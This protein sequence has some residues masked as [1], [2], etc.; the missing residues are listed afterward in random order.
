MNSSHCRKILPFIFAVL[1]LLLA[2]LNSFVFAQEQDR[3]KSELF[4]EIETA[5]K[6][7]QQEEVPAFAPSL[8]E[9]AIKLYKSAEKDYRD[10]ERLEDIRETLRDAVKATNEAIEAANISKITLAKASVMRKEAAQREYIKLAPSEFADAEKSYEDAIQKVEAGDIRAARKKTEEAMKSYREEII[11]AM[12][13]G[14]LKEAS[15]RLD[16]SKDV[17]SRE[18]VNKSKRDLGALEDQLDDARDQEFEIPVL[19][20][21]VHK[22]IDAIIC[23]IDPAYCNPPDTLVMGS[24]ILKVE[25]YDPGRSWD[26]ERNVMTNASGVAWTSFSCDFVTLFPIFSG[27]IKLISKTFQVV[28]I[29]S[30]TLTEINLETAKLINPEVKIGETLQLDIPSKSDLHADILKGKRDLIDLLGKPKGTI[31]VRFENLTIEP[32]AHS[33]VG[34]VLEGTAHYPTVPPTPDRITLSIAGFKVYI[35]SLLL[36]PAAATAQ[37][38]LEFPPSIVDLSECRPGRVSLGTISINSSCQ[39]HKELYDNTFGPWVMDNTG[40]VFGGTGFVA[41]FSTSWMVP[42]G[43]DLPPMLPAWRGVVLKSGGTVAHSSIDTSNVGFLY[44]S[45]R[46]TNATVSSSGLNTKLVLDSVSKYMTLAPLAYYIILHGGSLQIENGM[47]KEGSF[48]V[49]GELPSSVKSDGGSPIP[50]HFDSFKVDSLLNITGV[51][52]TIHTKIILSE[53]YALAVRKGNF[54]LPAAPVPLAPLYFDRST[55]NR[56]TIESI[57]DTM[58]LPGLTIYRRNIDSLM[59]SSKDVHPRFWVKRPHGWLN[60]VT[61]GGVGDIYLFGNPKETMDIQCRLGQPGTPGYKSDSTFATEFKD[62]VIV[63][64]VHNAVY[65]TYFKGDITIPYP[66]GAAVVGVKIPFYDMGFT[67]IGACVGGNPVFAD[68]ITLDYWGVGITSKWGVVSVRTGEILYTDAMITE[69]RHFALG[70]NIYWGEMRADGNLGNFF[71]NYNS[72][73]QKF[74]GFPFTIHNA[75]LSRY[76]PVPAFAEGHPLL[77]Y[78]EVEG[79][80]H[81][82]FWGSRTVTIRDYKYPD[83]PET[84]Y[85]LRY[86]RITPDYFAVQRNWGS[87]RADMNFP[88]VCYDSLDQDGFQGRGQVKLLGQL[89]GTIASLMD[90]SSIVSNIYFCLGETEEGAGGS[91]SD[92]LLTGAVGSITLGP[93]GGSIQIIGDKLERIYIEGPMEMSGD[94]GWLGIGAAMQIDGLM[95][96]EITP[97][98]LTLGTVAGISMTLVRVAGLQGM[99]GMKFTASTTGLQGDIFGNFNTF[100]VQVGAEGQFSFGVGYPPNPSFYFEGYAKTWIYFFGSGMKSEGAL[101][102]ALNAPRE[103]LWALDKIG[104][105]LTANKVLTSLGVASDARLTGFYGGGKFGGTLDLGIIGGGCWVWGGAGCFYITKSSSFIIVGN[106]GVEITGEVLYGL[107]SASL[108]AEMGGALDVSAI[109]P[110]FSLCGAAGIDVCCCWDL[111][112]FGWSGSVCIGTNGI[113][114]N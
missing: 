21:D 105:N 112:C 25:S 107:L 14:P 104:K 60:V 83:R 66:C 71:F 17:M 69:P 99:A 57:L 106:A 33:K 61:Q 5:I 88:V 22:K 68:T 31:K 13:K 113:K 100:P 96:V 4:R 27:N 54:F 7:A 3:V 11:I 48:A 70:F 43:P 28:P 92:V 45:Y 73:N 82:P 23:A 41:D 103:Q 47:V 9:K 34:K 93:I 37:A 65:D 67:S 35:D 79:D 1:I 109:P 49:A 87:G 53:S 39:F 89:D 85:N 10:G 84:P 97:T 15:A 8:F 94:V 51:V 44:G 98:S 50:F 74:D 111:I 90:M 52:D 30:D 101:V 40:I 59:I 19:I 95:T 91:A 6:K 72:G 46:F 114:T 55:Y 78:L 81:F 56:S 80:V 110:R 75:S 38:E 102:V 12:E 58:P 16:R 29:V 86:V 20:A 62:T 63:D 77:G 2:C 42:A 64:F 26:F 32:V 36:T 108:W 76:N 24:F 18:S